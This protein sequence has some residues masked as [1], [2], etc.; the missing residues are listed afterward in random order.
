MSG[1]SERQGTEAVVR[2]GSEVSAAS[3]IDA[4]WPSAGATQVERGHGLFRLAVVV[5]NCL[6]LISIVAFAWTAA[7]EYSTRR[8][9]TGFVDAIVPAAAAPEQKIEAIL[10]WMKRPPA[11]MQG[12]MAGGNDRDPLDTLNYKSLLKVCGTATNA[13]VNLADSAGL[14]SRRIL[15]LDSNGETKHVDAEVFVDGRWVVVDPTFRAILRGPDGKMLT[16]T[17][18]VEPGIF[19]AATQHIP[20]YDARYTFERTAHV[21]LTR[22]RFAGKAAGRVLDFVLPGWDDSVAVSIVLE[23]QSLMAMIAAI[24]VVLM[25]MLVRASLRRYAEQHLGFHTAHLGSRLRRA[26][27]AFFSPAS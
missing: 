20:R 14:P 3:P 11:R 17:E 16:R 23:R 22:L 24:T 26:Y 6:S 9:L 27:H 18:L 7:W 21:H 12:G 15:L 2:A 1:R 5:V 19:L 25:L 4:N 8:Y 13:F 10:D